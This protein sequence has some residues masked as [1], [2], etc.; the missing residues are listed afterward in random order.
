MQD[1]VG[2]GRDLLRDGKGQPELQP[3]QPHL[4]FG[5]VEHPRLDAAGDADA[6]PRTVYGPVPDQDRSETVHHPP[7]GGQ[8]LRDNDLP[9]LL[10]VEIV[11]SLFRK[12]ADRLGLK[13]DFHCRFL[14]VI[15]VDTI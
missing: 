12:I 5:N 15:P 11:I 14:L 9:G 4:P 1:R 10:L 3:L 2:L 8:R 7:Q 13:Q 6:S